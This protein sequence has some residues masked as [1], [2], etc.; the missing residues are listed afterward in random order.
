MNH[1]R[2]LFHI[3]LLTQNK[4]NEIIW[5]FQCSWS[6]TLLQLLNMLHLTYE[7]QKCSKNSECGVATRPQDDSSG[8]SSSYPAGQ[9]LPLSSHSTKRPF[10]GPQY[11]EVEV[12]VEVNL[13]PTVSRPVCLG[14]RSPS[15][16]FDHFFLSPWNFFQTSACLLFCSALSDERTGL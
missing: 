2:K 1:F 7:R 8:T 16:I 10:S 6:I 15:G 12:E 3:S 9:L 13:R 14:V 4:Q 11:V 5:E